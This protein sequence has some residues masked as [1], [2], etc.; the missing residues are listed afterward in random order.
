MS[1]SSNMVVMGRKYGSHD[2]FQGSF[3][4]GKTYSFRAPFVWDKTRDCSALRRL[5]FFPP[6]PMPTDTFA[7]PK[8]RSA[9][10]PALKTMPHSSEVEQSV[11]G[12]LFIDSDAAIKIADFLE[13]DDFYDPTHREIYAAI[14]SL[15]HK[16]HPIDL[17]TVST[18]LQDSERIN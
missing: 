1:L 16:H 4:L 17:L 13:A 8:A 14:L 18:E 15:Y 10:A 12:A 9:G 3:C 11:L 6:R 2:S 7:P 5:I